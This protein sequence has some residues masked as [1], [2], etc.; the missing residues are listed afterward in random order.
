MERTVLDNV[1]EQLKNFT[2]NGSWAVVFTFS[3]IMAVLVLGTAFY[4]EIMVTKSGL[5]IMGSWPVVTLLVMGKQ[6]YDMKKQNKKEE[7]E[8]DKLKIENGKS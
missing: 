7:L 4:V 8:V 6:Y 5:V 3:K 1:K 2:W